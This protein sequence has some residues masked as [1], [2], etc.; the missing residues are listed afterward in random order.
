MMESSF[1]PNKKDILKAIFV[2]L[3]FTLL[4]L[5]GCAPA[6][7]VEYATTSSIDAG[8]HRYIDREYNVVCYYREA[9]GGLDCIPLSDLE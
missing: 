7:D 3:V 6:T 5:Y 8:V 9:G 4:V 1:K 2:A